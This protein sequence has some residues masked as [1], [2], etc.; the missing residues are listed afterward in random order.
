MHLSIHPPTHTPDMY[1]WFPIYF[2]LKEPV[3]LP[4][5]VPIE[6]HLWRCGAHHKVGVDCTPMLRNTRYAEMLI[7]FVLLVVPNAC[8]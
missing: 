7:F 4:A 6:A 5:D 1:S 8:L 3:S 2:P